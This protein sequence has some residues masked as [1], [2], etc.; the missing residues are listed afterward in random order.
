MALPYVELP[1]DVF[2]P[3]AN[4]SDWLEVMEQGASPC[5]SHLSN[6]GQEA[7]LVG[8]VP[9]NKQRSCARYM[10]G[11]AYADEDFNLHRE[12]PCPHP[13]FPWLF[14]SEVS[15]KP[16]IPVT[17]PSAPGGSPQNVS[18]FFTNKGL[19]FGNHRTAI[20][21]AKFRS[22]RCSFLEDV[23][24]ETYQSEWRRNAIWDFTPKVEVLS[25]D[26]IGQLSW[27]ETGPVIGGGPATQGP[28]LKTP[29]PAPLA[30]LLSKVDIVLT[31][32][33]YP[34]EY[35]S[36]F[37]FGGDF[38]FNP[39]NII[40]GLKGATTVLGSVGT[41]NSQP[42][43]ATA[44]N[45]FQAGTLLMGPPRFRQKV[46]PVAPA[47][48]TKPLISIDIDVPFEYF[49]PPLGATAP[50]MP[51]HFN[52][53]WRGGELS[54]G[55]PDPTG[56]KYFYCTRGGDPTGPTLLPTTDFNRIFLSPNS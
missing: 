15:F 51:G 45:P 7:T 23:D 47:D 46:F 4:P 34:F 22:Y 54:P 2:D 42:F 30:Q 35:L 1:G 36:L 39:I 3:N 31:M 49:N 14:C 44:D 40:G 56:G 50:I 55:V 21:T 26:G 32:S 33:Q 29:F 37:D 27:A 43:P 9:R 5:E 17:N 10:L 25:V 52:L 24:I 16:Y 13:E 6:D 28:T 11:F 8:Y 19:N 12:N 38:L 48:P 41:V 53:P 20:C 18:L